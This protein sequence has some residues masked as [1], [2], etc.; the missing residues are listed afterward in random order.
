M[1]GQ[2]CFKGVYVDG[3]LTY[4]K[5]GVYTSI[6]RLVTTRTMQEIPQGNGTNIVTEYLEAEK[7]MPYHTTAFS[8]PV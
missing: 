3:L 6:I 5:T 1:G 2:I 4:K 7:V 8:S